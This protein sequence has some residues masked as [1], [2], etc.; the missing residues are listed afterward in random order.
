MVL[1][2]AINTEN[3]MQSIGASSMHLLDRVPSMAT[4]SPLRALSALNKIRPDHASDHL[5]LQEWSL[6]NGCGDFCQV[7]VQYRV[8]PQNSLISF[9]FKIANIT[10]FLI[11]DLAV[12]FQHSS[13]LQIRPNQSAS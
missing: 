3:T 10:N 12:S 2:T 5:L 11:E 4:A 8:E 9:T 6:I 1:D 7:Y 13:N